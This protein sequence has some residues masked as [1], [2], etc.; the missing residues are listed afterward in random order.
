MLYDG[1]CGL[2]N[3]LTRFVLEHDRRGL[4]HFASLQSADARTALEPFG[5]NPDDLTTLYVIVDYRRPTS[6]LLAKGR[7]AVF[8]ITRL[9]WPLRAAGLLGVL[10]NSILD[11]FYDVIA[12]NRYRIFGRH[13]RCVMPRLAFRSRFI[14]SQA[15]VQP[16][17]SGMA[18]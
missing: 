6:M 12:R 4:F 13:E 18:P 15:D 5:S 16:K 10:P 1:A 17:R 7:A 14:D 3:G 2:C 8:V 9:G 11:R